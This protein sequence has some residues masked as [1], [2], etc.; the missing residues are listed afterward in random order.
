MAALNTSNV[1][2]SKNTIKEIFTNLVEPNATN[3]ND[4]NAIKQ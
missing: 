2:Q 3:P 1:N 4:E